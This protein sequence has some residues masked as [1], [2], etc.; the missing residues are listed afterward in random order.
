MAAVESLSDEQFAQLDRDGFLVVRGVLPPGELAA[1]NARLDD[2]MAGRVV[3]PSLLMQLDP[4]A[5][6]PAGAAADGAAG[7]AAAAAEF[8]AYDAA[9]LQ[10][11]GQTAGFKGASRAYRKIG[12]A[13]CGLECDELFLR[14]MQRPLFRRACDRVYGAHAAIS[15]YRAM[16]MSKPAGPD[17][18]GSALPWHQDGGEW[19]AL[20][21]DPLLFVWIALT[22][23]TRANGAVQVV[24]G[25]H[26][27][28]LL[29]RRGHTLSAADVERVVGGG[30]V[31]DVELA[32][33]DAFFCHNFTV[34]R[35]GTNSTDAAR[36]GFSVNF[37][38]SRT[39]VLD[40]KPALAGSLGT[41]GGSFPLVF[42]S[43]H[44]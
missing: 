23:A 38:D 11:A 27:L 7:A 16:V 20:D 36:R 41:P 10:T 29:S 19:W 44:E 31:V 22:E 8:S 5:A 25:S 1:L 35:S 9:G 33:G 12:E 37:V 24:R 13:E 4:S 18:G 17:G 34:H 30:E 32:P 40:P 28:G 43:P 2:L 14:A 42:K 26:R 15:V 6:P 21:R 39:R 3:H